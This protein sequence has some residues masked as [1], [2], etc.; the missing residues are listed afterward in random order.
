MRYAYIVTS[1][2]QISNDFMKLVKSTNVTEGINML[3]TDQCPGIHSKEFKIFLRFNPRCGAK[4]VRG[5]CR[6]NGLKRA[7]NIFC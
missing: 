2:I 3:L 7:Y 4:K 6:T 1:K 5:A